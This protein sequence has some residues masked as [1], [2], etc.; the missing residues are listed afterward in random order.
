[1]DCGGASRCV[2]TVDDGAHAVV[3]CNMAGECGVGGVGSAEVDC[4]GSSKCTVACSADFA[5]C[6]DCEEGPEN[7]CDVA[8]CQV[9]CVE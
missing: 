7:A 1:V 8:G 9:G 6:A 5:A 2:V 4:G 3:D